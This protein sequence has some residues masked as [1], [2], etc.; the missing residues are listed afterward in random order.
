MEYVCGVWLC[1]CVSLA[2]WCM[3]LCIFQIQFCS[4]FPDISLLFYA[5]RKRNNKRKEDRKKAEPRMLFF[6]WIHRK[7]IPSGNGNSGLF[8]PLSD[9]DFCS[10]CI[11]FLC[12]CS[13]SFFT[14]PIRQCLLISPDKACVYVC[15]WCISCEK[16]RT[17]NSGLWTNIKR[18]KKWIAVWCCFEWYVSCVERAT[19]IFRKSIPFKL[20]MLFIKW[21]AEN[22][23]MDG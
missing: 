7:Y 5:M 12:C 3:F 2:I 10:L 18:L 16:W 4:C 8:Y 1:V 19:T 14:M 17:E 13:C 11:Y 9:I 21:H 23:Y 20:N 22:Q 6:E 15:V